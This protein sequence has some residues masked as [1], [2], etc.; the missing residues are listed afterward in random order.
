MDCTPWDYQNSMWKIKTIITFDA[1]KN[2]EPASN[3]R[4]KQL[5]NLV[6]KKLQ[7]SR[8]FL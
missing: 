6:F 2:K 5:R 7:I 4:C 3:S 8:I 1:V